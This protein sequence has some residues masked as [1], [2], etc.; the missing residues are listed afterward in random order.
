MDLIGF[1]TCLMATVDVA[2]TFSDIGK[3][4]VA[5][6]EL[7]PGN[8]WLYS[9]WLGALAKDP[10]M[11]AL[12]LGKAICDT[13]KKG[14]EALETADNITLSVTNLS[15]VAELV[16]AYDAFGAQA[17]VAASKD[18]GFFSKFGRLAAA[19]ENYGGNTKEQGFTNMVDMGHLARQASSLLPDVSKQVLDALNACVEYKVA[20]SY[21]KESTGLSCYYSYNGDAEDFGKYAALGAGTAIKHFYSYGLTGKLDEA[22]RH[23]LAQLDISSMPEPVTLPVM[24]WDGIK[25]DV[26]KDGVTVLC[27][28]DKAESVLAGIGFQLYYVDAENDYMLLL[29]SDN[30]IDADWEKGMFKDNFRGKWGAID[31]NLVYMELYDEG[32]DYNLY[33]VPIKLNGEECNLM[34]V[35]DFGKE[36][37]VIQGAR[38]SLDE[39]GMADKNLRKLKEGDQITAIHY[40]NQFS[41]G[42]DELTPFDASAFTVT[43]DTVFAESDLGDGKFVMIFEMWDAQG[44]YAYSDGVVFDCEDG[45][46]T[47]SVYDD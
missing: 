26:D 41:L 44:N 9:G 45:E 11:D 4:L 13:Y 33:A 43:K 19:T 16:K 38:H 29:G 30:D 8:G 6:E 17:L 12:G 37:W 40:L 21:R 24:N 25:L 32:A 42:S 14:C 2:R 35:Y 20:G 27:L 5:S 15:K 3:Y 36:S 7:E 23:Y 31:G 34:V 10:D 18:D 28:G 22:G 47:T 1:D 39:S 46:I